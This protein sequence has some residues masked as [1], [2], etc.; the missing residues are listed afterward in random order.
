MLDD[1]FAV[2]CVH[3]KVS[4]SELCDVCESYP[5]PLRQ[6]RL[7]TVA[8]PT[9]SVRCWQ[10]L[11]INAAGLAAVRVK[12]VNLVVPQDR[13]LWLTAVTREAVWTP[14]DCARIGVHKLR[15]ALRRFFPDAIAELV[16]GYLACPA[17]LTTQASI[18]AHVIH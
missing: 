9:H 13:A 15:R 10:Q 11:P 5:R 7:G 8:A 12:L 3:V 4:G 16:R 1:A 2:L 17:L 18:T 6:L 14:K